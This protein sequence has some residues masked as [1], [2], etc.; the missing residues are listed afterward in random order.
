MLLSSGHSSPASS[1]PVALDEPRDGTIDLHKIVL[2]LLRGYT[3]DSC[4]ATLLSVQELVY[5]CSLARDV[6]LEQPMLLELDA[7]IVLVG[8]LHGNYQDLLRI[9]A[10]TGHPPDTCYLFLGDYVDRG[11]RSLEVIS[12]LMAYKILYPHKLYLLRGNHETGAVSRVMGFKAEIESR[13]ETPIPWF[14]F[15][16][17]FNCLPIAAVVANTIF[18]VHGGPPD[19]VSYGPAKIRSMV[20]PTDV[21]D[22]SQLCVMLWSDPDQKDTFPD[23]RCSENTAR[24][25]GRFYNMAHVKAFLR[26]HNLS[27][28]VRAHQPVAGG[29][30]FFPQ[31]LGITLFSSSDYMGAGNDAAIMCIDDQLG[32]HLDILKPQRPSD[33]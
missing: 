5:L 20:R 8:D 7:P 25:V 18:C 10:K 32:C 9:F 28:L 22:A 29:Y 23:P 12:L 27:Y 1:T 33:A 30:K 16:A 6:F 3:L 2:T 31:K 19:D 21:P 15:V 26:A 11:A 24:G 17:S 14:H 4:S 13:C